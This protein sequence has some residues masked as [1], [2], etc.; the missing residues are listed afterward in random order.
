MPHVKLEAWA[1][2]CEGMISQK[3]LLEMKYWEEVI[4]NVNSVPYSDSLPPH[5]PLWAIILRLILQVD[6]R[7]WHVQNSLTTHP[8]GPWCSLPPLPSK[9]IQ[10]NNLCKFAYLVGCQPAGPW[11]YTPLFSA[12]F[13]KSVRRMISGLL[14]REEGKWSAQGCPGEGQRACEGR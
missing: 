7:P 6:K 14:G 3:I 9:E 12:S 11:S 4:W 1:K 5:S 2:R 8:D 10:K 13:G